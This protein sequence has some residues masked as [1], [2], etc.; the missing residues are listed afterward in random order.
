MEIDIKPFDNTLRYQTVYVVGG[1][2]REVDHVCVAKP[3]L[4]LEKRELS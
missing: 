1:R 4:L 2:E 3:L